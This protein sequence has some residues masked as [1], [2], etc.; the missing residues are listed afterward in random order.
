MESWSKSRNSTL[1][2]P[3]GAHLPYLI[4]YNLW[5][6]TI[7][8]HPCY[9]ESVGGPPLDRNFHP[10]LNIDLLRCEPNNTSASEIEKIVAILRGREFSDTFRGF[11]VYFSDGSH[12]L[13]GKRDG[14][15]VSFPIQGKQGER[16][17]EVRVNVDQRHGL[18]SLQV[19]VE[20]THQ[21]APTQ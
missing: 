11:L 21:Q 14:V 20:Y 8:A 15:E 2:A 18:Q 4:R 9:F 19:S 13:Y 17:S 3:P 16:V 6:P 10:L 5:T 12:V 7:P 1:D